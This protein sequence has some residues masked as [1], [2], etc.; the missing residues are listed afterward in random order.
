LHAIN[1]TSS[2]DD[3]CSGFHGSASIGNRFFL[4]C[5]DIHGGILL[6]DYDPTTE[7][8]TSRAIT[9]PDNDETFSGLRVGSFA[10]HYLAPA[11]IGMF[12]AREGTEYYLLS[13]AGDATS[14]G[15]QNILKLPGNTRQCG[16][17][18]EVGRGRRLL[19]LMP[20]GV[21]HVFEV[22]DD[23]S[24]MAVMNQSIVP[25]MTAC[26]EAVFVAGIGQAFVATVGTKILYAVDLSHVDEG[27]MDVYSTTLPFTPTTLTVSGF[28]LEAACDGSHSHEHDADADNGEDAPSPSAAGRT[29]L[30]A[31]FSA[32]VVA[33]VIGTLM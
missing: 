4:A 22:N 17:M 6:V 33:S 11:V 27:E 18:F 24:F 9:Y 16:V 8:Y 1:D 5:D 12:S 29:A 28:S 13:I 23:G 31:I 20:D 10:Y 19:V 2:Q 15:E 21:L 25:G 7:S 26:S 3:H 14:I 32:A 30:S